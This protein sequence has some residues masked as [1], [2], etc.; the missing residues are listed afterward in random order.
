MCA[1]V[2]AY[3]CVYERMSVCACARASV[4]GC[5]SESA[6]NGFLI[7]R[8]QKQIIRKKHRPCSG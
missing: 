1:Y 8:N 7:L 2:C 5:R 6:H 3:A 4:C